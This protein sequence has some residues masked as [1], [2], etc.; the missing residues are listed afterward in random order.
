MVR[1][2]SASIT[3]IRFESIFSAPMI[4]APPTDSAN[5][6]HTLPLLGPAE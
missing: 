5:I 3:R 1:I 2:P 6:A 4:G